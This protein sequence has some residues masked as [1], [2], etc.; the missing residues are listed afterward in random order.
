MTD[1]KP[2]P[3]GEESLV[4]AGPTRSVS[5]VCTKMYDQVKSV[6]GI[7]DSEEIDATE[8][9]TGEA[10]NQGNAVEMTNV[11]KHDRDSWPCT[12]RDTWLGISVD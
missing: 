2:K 7:E 4:P 1:G 5:L 8:G 10:T 11:D 3:T 12:Y 9:L 6:D